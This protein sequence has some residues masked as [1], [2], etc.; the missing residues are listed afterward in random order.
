MNKK[1]YLNIVFSLVLSII[2]FIPFASA[3]PPET[4]PEQIGGIIEDIIGILGPILKGIMGEFDS[5]EFLIAKGLLL[6]LLIVIISTILKR[7]PIGKNNEKTANIIAIIISILA[8]RFINDNQLIN[9]ILLPYGTLGVAITTILPFVIFFYFVHYTNMGSFARKISWAFFAI[10]FLSL[11]L[12]REGLSEVSNQIY[13]WTMLAMIIIFF[14]DKSIHN[15]M[16]N[17]EIKDIS[18][19]AKQRRLAKLVAEFNSYVNAGGAYDSNIE[20]VMK[21]LESEIKKLRKEID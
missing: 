4:I 3:G 19:K 6:I 15:Y 7:T 10:I 1:N 8:V 21:D 13:G 11:W 14:F 18:K 20:S 5:E 9:G 17:K 2:L 12:T 16:G